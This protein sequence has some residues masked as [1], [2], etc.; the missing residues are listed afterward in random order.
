MRPPS[1][2]D[3]RPRAPSLERVTRRAFLGRGRTG[4]GSV[5]AG[6]AA[7]TRAVSPPRRGERG[8]RPGVVQPPALRAAGQAGDLPLHGRRAV[9][10]G[11]LRLTSRSS[12][13]CTA[14]RC[15]S[16]SPRASRS[17]SSRTRSSTAS[18]RSI[19]SRSTA[20]PARRSATLFPHI[21]AVAD[22]ICI[23]RSLQTEPINHDPA[24]TFMNTGTPDLR[25][26]GHGLVA[27][28]R[29]GQRGRRPARLRRAHVAGPRRAE[30][31]DR[32]AAV[33]QRLPARAGSRACSSAAR[34]TPCSTCATPRASTHAQQRDVVDA[35]QRA[36][37][38]AARRVD[39]PEIARGSPV[40]D[41]VPHADQRARADGHL[42]R[43]REHRSTCTASRAGDGTFAANC[44]LARRLAE[45]GVRFIQ[46]YHRDWDHHGGIKGDIA[47]KAAR[48]RPGRRR[49]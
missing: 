22:E 20:S 18:A 47:M 35:V 30:A 33:A 12:P 2:P 34:A 9:A 44:L 48:G 43:A 16:R 4:L 1:S 24:H 8:A 6:V 23:I 27:L 19:R 41:G 42:E 29:P 45:R 38:G 40:R 31:A 3:R 5:G 7:R 15:R 36:H 37:R 14:S 32:R 21:G 25:P 39:D 17:P 49:R 28:L 10:P 13:R 46:L 11:D 26:A